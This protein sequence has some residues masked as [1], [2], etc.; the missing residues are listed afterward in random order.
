MY[1]IINKRQED[2]EGGRHGD[3]RKKGHK[4]RFEN[5]GYCKNCGEKD[6]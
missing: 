6:D 4:K 3:K 1:Q 5:Q 2:G